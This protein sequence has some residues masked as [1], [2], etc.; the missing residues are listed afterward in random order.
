MT[1]SNRVAWTHIYAEL[2]AD[3]QAIINDWTRI[4]WARMSAVD[5]RNGEQTAQQ[6]ALALVWWVLNHRQAMAEGEKT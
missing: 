4:I 2:P 6:V 3:I 1:K 5:A